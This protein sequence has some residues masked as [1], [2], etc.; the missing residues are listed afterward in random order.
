MKIR[1]VIDKLTVMGTLTLVSI[2][3]P[4]NY[5]EISVYSPFELIFVTED[6]L[7]VSKKMKD[8][9]KHTET[10]GPPSSWLEATCLIVSE[11]QQSKND[12]RM[13]NEFQTTARGTTRKKSKDKLL[14]LNPSPLTSVCTAAGRYWLPESE[15]V[16]WA[17][18]YI[19]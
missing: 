8:R 10:L 11:E 16:A 18:S 4:N 14:K 15:S 12:K 3:W 17:N 19:M 2:G 5:H 1:K 7:S 9:K 13:R 6:R